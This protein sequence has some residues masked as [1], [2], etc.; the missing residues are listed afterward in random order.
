MLIYEYNKKRNEYL[1]NH[2][3]CQEKSWL[4]KGLDW[5]MCEIVFGVHTDIHTKMSKVFGKS[6]KLIRLAT[7]F[8]RLHAA[9][10]KD[11]IFG[12]L[13]KNAKIPF[14]LYLLSR[15]DESD[16]IGDAYFKEG[17]GCFITIHDCLTHEPIKNLQMPYNVFEKVVS[18]FLPIIRHS[19]DLDFRFVEKI[20]NLKQMRSTV[21]LSIR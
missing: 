1:C 19:G 8:C 13:T 6:V 20:K 17:F 16:I 15:E 11:I 14:E 18:G 2:I 9:T 5:K 7:H 21:N 10:Y 4:G 12:L 3:S